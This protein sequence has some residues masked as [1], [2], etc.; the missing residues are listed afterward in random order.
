MGSGKGY[1]QALLI[2]RVKVSRNTKKIKKKC[3][4]RLTYRKMG[5]SLEEVIYWPQLKNFF[6]QFR[7]ITLRNWK[8]YFPCS[9]GYLK[10]TN[11]KKESLGVYCRKMTGKSVSVSGDQAIITFFSGYYVRR[12]FRLS[13]TTGSPG[14][15]ILAEDTSD[16]KIIN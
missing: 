2:K 1:Q 4:H 6:F 13:F 15:N 11:E 14:K 16:V 10:I 12:R 3:F 7:H 9:D 8:N 5:P